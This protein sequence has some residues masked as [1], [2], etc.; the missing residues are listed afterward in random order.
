MSEENEK[1]NHDSIL[2]VLGKMGKELKDSRKEDKKLLLMVVYM[3]S[4]IMTYMYLMERYSFNTYIFVTMFYFMTVWG[5][6]LFIATKNYMERPDIPEYCIAI[7]IASFFLFS[8][9]LG[10]PLR[11]E[12]AEL[13][14]SEV[15]LVYLESVGV[16]LEFNESYFELTFLNEGNYSI[17]YKNNTLSGDLLVR[18]YSSWD[19]GEAVFHKDVS[20]LIYSP[21]YSRPGLYLKIIDEDTGSYSEYNFSFHRAWFSE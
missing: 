2:A 11:I 20:E 14:N 16:N 13:Y 9:I 17:E 10:A 3:A 4:I 8:I 1:G 18:Q 19:V 5:I 15:R 6:A 21:P 12:S 7:T